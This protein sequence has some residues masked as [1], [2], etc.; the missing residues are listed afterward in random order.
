M[1]L[2]GNFLQKS[3]ASFLAII[4]CLKLEFGSHIGH[5]GEGHTLQTKTLKGS[6]DPGPSN[7]AA[8]IPALDRL[9]NYV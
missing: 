4:C 6:R 2:L 3:L 5:G 7:H 9:P 8:T 1:G